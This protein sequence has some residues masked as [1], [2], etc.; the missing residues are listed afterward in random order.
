MTGKRFAENVH[1]PAWGN[2][3]VSNKIVHVRYLDRFTER[4][5]KNR[6]TTAKSK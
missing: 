2:V 1:L 6:K 3:F 4:N 5:A